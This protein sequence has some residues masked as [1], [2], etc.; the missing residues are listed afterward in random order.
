[1]L[2]NLQK[3]LDKNVTQLISKTTDF[4]SLFRSSKTKNELLEKAQYLGTLKAQV[5]YAKSAEREIQGALF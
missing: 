3:K 5:N 4:F 1:M 2:N